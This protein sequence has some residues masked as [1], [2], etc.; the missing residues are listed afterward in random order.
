MASVWL[1]LSECLSLPG[2]MPP[3]KQTVYL[4]VKEAGSPTQNELTNSLDRVPPVYHITEIM[5]A[6][7]VMI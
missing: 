5:C 1:S 3:E 7:Y 2:F 4:P 6:H